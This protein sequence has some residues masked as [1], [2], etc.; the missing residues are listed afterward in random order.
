MDRK[1][2]RN[3]CED[4]RKQ[5]FSLNSIMVKTNLPKSTVYGYIKNVGLT[6][7]QKNEM[8][9]RKRE[10]SKSRINPRK[11]VCLAGRGIN[12]PLGWSPRLINAV[13]HFMFDGHVC[14]D[15]CTYYN[16]SKNQVERLKELI[17]QIFGIKPKLHTRPDGVIVMAFHNVEFAAYI[18]KKTNEIFAYLKERSTK[19]EKREFLKA[20]FDDEGNIYYNH[21][22]KR[23]VRGYQK[24]HKILEEISCLLKEFGI[25]ARIDIHSKAI[26]ISDRENLSAFAREINFSPLIYMNPDRK[27]SI[28]R[29][30]IEK[31]EIL[32][33]AVSSYVI[34][35]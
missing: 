14:E 29:K 16:R 18:K 33:I 9:K 2:I 5:G 3:T 26:E 21:R 19:E 13:A 31:R 22:D 10:L 24:S 8:L 12:R 7:H 30:E 28:W 20:F 15:G 17:D 27:N 34:K 4:L 1:S 25:K 32:K 6:Q 35:G 23:R 11:G